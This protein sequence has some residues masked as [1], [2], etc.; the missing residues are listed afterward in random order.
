MLRRQFL[1]LATSMAAL[2]VLSEISR[3]QSYPSRPITMIVAFPAGGPADAAA[4]TIAER[5]RDTLGQSVIV[6]NVSGASGT[7]GTGRAARAMADGY[8]ICAGG[9][10]THVING[11]L[12]S[13]SYDVANDFEPISLNA[14]FHL[15]FVARKSL[16]ANDLKGLIDWLKA[17]PDRAS[18]GNAGA[19][20]PGHLAGLAFQKETGTRFQLVPYRGNGPA[21]QD[22]VSGQ[23]DFMFSDPVVALPQV[24]AG[25]VKALAVAANKRMIS[26]PTIPTVDEAGMPGFYVSNWTAAFAP[27]GTSKDLLSNL[28]QAVASSLDDPTVRSRLANFGFEVFPPE[29]RG[30]SALAV[31]Q[32]SEIEKWWPII[33]AA[34]IKGE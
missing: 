29:Q 19:G 16:P 14:A 26:A 7:I 27:K 15:I 20:T 21:I 5:M 17:N 2:P 6:E 13:L 25:T 30:P 32:R 3:A 23:L 8:T 33:K 1:H 11:A 12:Y 9:L 4:R 34:N 24:R 28:S 10:S 22:L 31:F 18:A